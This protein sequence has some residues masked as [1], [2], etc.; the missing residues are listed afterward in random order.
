MSPTKQRFTRILWGYSKNRPN[1]LTNSYGCNIHDNLLSLNRLILNYWAKIFI[2]RLVQNFL[3]WSLIRLVFEGF[4]RWL[5]ARQERLKVLTSNSGHIEWKVKIL[6][7]EENWSIWRNLLGKTREQR[8]VTCSQGKWWLRKLDTQGEKVATNHMR[9]LN[10]NN[11]KI[12]QRCNDR[13]H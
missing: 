13:K 3:Q 2:L 9:W 10:R 8:N 1:S 12:Q 11:D 4:S 7:K 6:S 5:C